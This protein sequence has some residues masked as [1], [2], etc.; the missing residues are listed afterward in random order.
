MFSGFL[1]TEDGV[2]PGNLGLKDQKLA[3]Q[4][5]HKNIDIF[6]GN[7]ALITIGGHGAGAA[8]VSYHLLHDANKGENVPG[9]LTLSSK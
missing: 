9:V 4:W 6:G 8:S 7:P 1:T 5:V 3:L 2:I